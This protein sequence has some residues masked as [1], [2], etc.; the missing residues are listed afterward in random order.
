MLDTNVVLDWLLFERPSLGALGAAI[1]AGRVG[2]TVSAVLRAEFALVVERGIRGW[3]AEPYPLLAAWDRWA[4]VR[5]AAPHG[6][7]PGRLRCTD[8]SDQKF[9]DLAVAT[10][11]RALLTRDRA[12]LKVA[13]RAREHGVAIVTPERWTLE[14]LGAAP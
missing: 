11:A 8:A 5:E 2:W 9:I 7:R 12:V 14:T 13:R 1:V 6:I 3:P 10:G 4:S